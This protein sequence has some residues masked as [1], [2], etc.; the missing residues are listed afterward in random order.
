M[1]KNE[2]IIPPAELWLGSHDA[3]IGEAHLYLQKFF[4][5]HGGCGTCTTCLQIRQQQHHGSIWI[6]P[7]KGYTLESLAVIFETMAFALQ[8]DQHI[9]FVLQKA[10]YLTTA[11]AN[12]LL[13]S[14]E[15]PKAGYHFLLLAQRA[16][17]LLPTI[18]SRC[19]IKAFTSHSIDPTYE[20]LFLLLSAGTKSD[21][22]VFL[23]AIEA[24]KINERESCELLD[25]LL[26]HWIKIYS[27]AVN[28]GDKM[29]QKKALANIEIFKA[30]LAEPPMPGS[31]KLFWKNI[32]MSLASSHSNTSGQ[33]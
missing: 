8:P 5:T 10:D 18:K 15:E 29:G 1:S 13:K 27:G 33:A 6:A 20:Q 11:C 19:I 31:S 21:A 14:L 23:K 28:K 24:S 25:S 3:L 4:C 2:L 16:D 7:E 30:A 32:H 12:S 22:T 17:A 26:S 9:F